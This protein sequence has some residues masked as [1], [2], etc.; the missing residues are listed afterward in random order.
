MQ[1]R[2]IG[3]PPNFSYSKTVVEYAK[4]PFLYGVIMP[5]EDAPL[6]HPIHKLGIRI[7]NINF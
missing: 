4:Y 2:G 1:G 7:Q 3:I 6:F 5:I